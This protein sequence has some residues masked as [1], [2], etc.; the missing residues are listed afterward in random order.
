LHSFEIQKTLASEI[1]MAE[2]L[3]HCPP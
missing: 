3:A 2:R 1:N